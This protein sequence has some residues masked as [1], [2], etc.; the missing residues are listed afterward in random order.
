MNNYQRGPGNSYGQYNQNQYNPNWRNNHPNLS[1][2]DTINTL[3]PQQNFNAPE[4]KMSTE[5]MFGQLMMELKKGNER[6]AENELQIKNQSAAIKNI[7]MQLG[8]LHNA[9]SQRPQGAFP[10]DTEKNPREQAHAVTL[11]SGTKYEGPTQKEPE[12]E[13]EEVVRKDKNIVEE[14]DHKDE[15]ENERKKKEEEAMKRRMEEHARNESVPFPGRLRKQNEDKNYKK[16]L[17][18][19]R[20]L[21]INIPLAD[22]LEQMPKYAK[23]LKDIINKKRRLGDHETVMLTE[24]SSALLKNK[25]PPKL[26]DPGSFSI[27]CTIGSLHFQNALCD[28]GASVN[29]LPYSLVKRLGI[30]EVKPTSIRL[31][32]VDR[33]TV[34]PRGILEDVL[35]KVQHLIFPI[36][37]VVLDTKENEVGIP[38]ILGRSFLRTART[39]IDVY[40]GKLTLRIGDDSVEFNFKNEMKYPPEADDCLNISTEDDFFDDLSEQYVIPSFEKYTENIISKEEENEELS[41]NEKYFKTLMRIEEIKDM[42]KPKTKKKKD[43]GDSYSFIKLFDENKEFKMVKKSWWHEEYE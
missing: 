35:I 37:I 39:I 23:Y 12:V 7:D 26:T 2:S 20:G 6:T 8:Q 41:K 36:D 27:P 17:E 15:V 33:S 13:A 5:D 24:E 14:V 22:A 31:Q 9:I 43:K 34:R 4:K 38:L 1:W 3:Q 30:G 18:M 21:R 11:R 29:I 19:F 10:S 28:L 32:L 25:L 42:K 16:F 40:E